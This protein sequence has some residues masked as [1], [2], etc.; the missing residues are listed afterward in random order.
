MPASNLIDKAM[1]LAFG[2]DRADLAKVTTGAALLMLGGKATPLYLFHSGLTG[3]EADWR[4]RHSFDGS[5]AERWA[6]ATQF[7]ESTHQDRTNRMLHMIGIPMIVGGTAGLLVLPSWTPPWG[8]AWGAFTVGWALNLLGHKY[9]EKNAPAFEEDPL[10]FLAGP[11]WD[12]K[13]IRR[14]VA[15]ELSVRLPNL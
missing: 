10:S 3:L 7:Y 12:L 9:F 14:A 5:F 8:L 13:H 1:D 4:K 15:S 6:Y 11:I 2:R